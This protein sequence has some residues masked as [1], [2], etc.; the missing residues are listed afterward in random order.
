L[1]VI[2]SY[3]VHREKHI[4]LKTTVGEIDVSDDLGKEVISR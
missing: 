4:L 2:I 1:E 3:K